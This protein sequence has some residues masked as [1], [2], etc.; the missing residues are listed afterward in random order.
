MC[1]YVL[2][3]DEFIETFLNEMF[4]D[5]HA[6]RMRKDFEEPVKKIAEQVLERFCNRN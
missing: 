4:E 5:R 6:R 1:V 2:T 3:H